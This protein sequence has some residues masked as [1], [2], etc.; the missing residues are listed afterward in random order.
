MKKYTGHPSQAFEFLKMNLVI[1]HDINEHM[2]LTSIFVPCVGSMLIVKVARDTFGCLEKGARDLFGCLK[3]HDVRKWS[4][5]DQ[6][7]Q[8]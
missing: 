6:T 3:P 8:P 5:A 1:K 4:T 7:K 2:Q